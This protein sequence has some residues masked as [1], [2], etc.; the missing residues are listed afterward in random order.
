MSHSPTSRTCHTILIRFIPEQHGPLF[1]PLLSHFSLL[2]LLS[3]FKYLKRDL[4]RKT[5]TIR[6]HLCV[7]SKIWHNWTYPWNRNRTRDIENWLV[8]AK[9]VGGGRGLDWE[10]G[11]SRCKL[12]YIGWINNKVLLNST[13]NYIQYPVI[14]HNGKEYEKRMSLCITESLRCTAEIGTT[15]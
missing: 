3:C 2:F 13:G 7:E 10:F 8:V 14:N 1:L 11:I 5:N 15:L 6:Y 9:G 12:V 4:K